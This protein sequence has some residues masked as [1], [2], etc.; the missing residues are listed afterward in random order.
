M[1]KIPLELATAGMKLAKLVNNKRGM[2][3]CSAGTELTEN[4]IA[5]LSN[6]GVK[7][8]TV[9]GHPVDTED[10]E[11]SLSQQIDELHAR[12]KYVEGDPLMRKI[13]DIFLERL[14]EMAEEA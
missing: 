10:R 13:K 14:K 9:E 6:M 5:R 8:I 7:R 2:P 1:Q 11:K 3:L 4:I 12:F